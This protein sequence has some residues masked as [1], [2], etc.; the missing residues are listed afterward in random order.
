MQIIKPHNHPEVYTLEVR[1]IFTRLATR[2]IA[3]QEDTILLLYTARY[4]DYSLPGGG[5]DLGE[6]KVSGMV[7][8]LSEETRATNINNIKS[9]GA[10]E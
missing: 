5:L 1:S 8:E 9:F 2:S 4:E 6:D 3:V 10:Y 7:R